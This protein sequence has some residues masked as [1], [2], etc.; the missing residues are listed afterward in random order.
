MRQ[1]VSHD[2]P[3]AVPVVELRASPLWGSREVIASRIGK[4]KQRR[5]SNGRRALHKSILLMPGRCGGLTQ[6]LVAEAL[7]PVRVQDVTNWVSEHVGDTLQA[8]RSREFPRSQ[9][10]KPGT[11]SADPLADTG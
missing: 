1:E 5:E 10:H 11:A 6:A 4:A 2:V 3:R 7:A 9:A 8:K